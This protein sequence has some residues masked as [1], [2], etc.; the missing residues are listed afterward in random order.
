MPEPEQDPDVSRRTWLAAERTWLAWWRTGVAVGAAALAVG[1]FLPAVSKGVTWPFRVLGIG[2]GALSVLIL[3]IGATRQRDAAT[4]LKRGSFAEL[5]SPTVSWLTAA[6]V[7]LSV[8][9]TVLVFAS[10]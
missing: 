1:R 3:L 2:Y 8:L 7:L 6:A 9:A 4:A 5:S 10:L